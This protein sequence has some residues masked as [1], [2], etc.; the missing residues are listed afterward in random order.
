[1]LKK[2]AR[3]R[4]IKLEEMDTPGQEHGAKTGTR[5][6]DSTRRLLTGREL[7]KGNGTDRCWGSG[8]LAQVMAVRGRAGERIAKNP[9]VGKKS[10]NQCPCR[11]KNLL[12]L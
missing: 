3:K 4:H 11:L 2:N 12:D 6:S 1:M 5:S 8:A 10:Q 7:E 9:V